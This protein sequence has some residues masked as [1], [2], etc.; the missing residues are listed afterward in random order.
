MTPKTIRLVRTSWIA[1]RPTAV[2]ATE[3]FYGHLA[4]LDPALKNKFRGILHVF[5]AAVSQLAY[6][7]GLRAVL[8]SI[9]ERHANHG[10][11]PADYAIVGAS[12]YTVLEDRLGA[13][14]NEDV[15][16]A[17]AEVYDMLVGEMAG[18]AF[19]PA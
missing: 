17:W 6:M 12:L 1:A 8:R 5:D 18:E 15:R 2:E 14:F 19:E 11:E 13:A 10:V 9:G 16:E 4:E 3:A 7:N